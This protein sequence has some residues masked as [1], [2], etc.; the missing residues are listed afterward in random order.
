[1][2]AFI[3]PMIVAVV[4]VLTSASYTF[5]EQPVAAGIYFASAVAILIHLDWRG[6]E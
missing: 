3:P 1:M 4:A 5:M 2:H 6:R